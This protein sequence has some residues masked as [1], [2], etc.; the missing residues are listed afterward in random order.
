MSR[1]RFEATPNKLAVAQILGD[2]TRKRSHLFAALQ[3]HY[4]FDDRYGRPAKGSDKGA[5]E[6]MIGFARRTFMV[7]I[8]RARDIDELN[9]ETLS[10]I[11]PRTMVECCGSAA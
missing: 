6:G 1:H 3:S 2:G 4:L 9:D 7:P 11:G 8:P 10:A 5:V